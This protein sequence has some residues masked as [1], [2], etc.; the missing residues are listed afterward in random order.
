MDWGYDQESFVGDFLGIPPGNDQ[1]FANWKI[2]M[3][4]D[5][6]SICRPCSIA[7]LNYV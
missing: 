5:T 4:M 1:Q 6:S 2:P 3:L 7:M